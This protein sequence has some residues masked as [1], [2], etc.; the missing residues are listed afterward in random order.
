MIHPAAAVHP[1]SAGDGKP[2]RRPRSRVNPIPQAPC[3][4]MSAGFFIRVDVAG[5]LPCGSVCAR[6]KASLAQSELFTG[7][8][9]CSLLWGRSR[10][11]AF[12]F[13]P[14]GG[15]R[16]CWVYPECFSAASSAGCCSLV[17]IGI[18]LMLVTLDLLTLVSQHHSSPLRLTT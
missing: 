17:E 1:V 8:S 9:L 12:I 4:R 10:V 13:R 16:V 3:S 6:H 15:G 5:G 2:R 14:G 11:H 18:R 7:A